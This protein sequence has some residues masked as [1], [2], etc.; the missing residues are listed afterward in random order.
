MGAICGRCWGLPLAALLGWGVLVGLM[1]A[2]H[3]WSWMIEYTLWSSV[4]EWLMVALACLVLL[5]WLGMVGWLLVRT[6]LGVKLRMWGHVAGCWACSMLSGGLALLIGLGLMVLTAFLPDRF[7]YGLTLP[8]GRDFVSPR[9]LRE[10]QGDVKP[11]SARAR[12]LLNLRPRREAPSHQVALP[13]L[14]NLEELS[15]EA[16]DILQEYVLR[17]LYAESVNPRFDAPVLALWQDEVMLG[18]ADDPQTYALYTSEREK[19]EWRRDCEV[20]RA[21]L[22]E[23]QWK[24]TLHNGWSLVLNFKAFYSPGAPEPPGGGCMLALDDSL[25]GLAANSTREYLDSILPPVPPGPFLCLWGTAGD[26]GVYKA[27]VILP[28]DYPEGSIS[29]CARE[30]TTGKLIGRWKELPMKRLGRVCCVAVD[31]AVLVEPGNWN[32]FYASTW[33]IWFHPAD[34]SD[35]R[36]VGSQD[37]LM[38]GWQH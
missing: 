7:A 15:A 23:W 10:L 16:P 11:A 35:S 14:P 19:K 9:G 4:L 34:G 3:W 21:E 8:E 32:E 6:V 1:L 36:C 25:K 33:E 26:E 17:C 22:P 28:A 38:M 2:A 29:L 13:P 30:V 31:A 18:H 27:V 37:F 20:E 24:H 12:E 5:L